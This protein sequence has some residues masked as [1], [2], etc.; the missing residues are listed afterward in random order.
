MFLVPA[1][2]AWLLSWAAVR[3]L[4]VLVF[5]SASWQFCASFLT[6]F[7]AAPTCREKLGSRLSAP[8][9]PTK[10][11]VAARRPWTT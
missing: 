9:P 1:V 4:L 7:G 2:N 10:S 3:D 11:C 6:T 8:L 5:Y